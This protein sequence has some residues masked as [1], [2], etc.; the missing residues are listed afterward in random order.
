M[1]NTVS[2][3]SS[4]PKLFVVA[5]I[6]C[7]LS[8]SLAVK[9]YTQAIDYSAG[10]QTDAGVA[11]ADGSAVPVGSLMAFGYYPTAL[12]TPITASS[13]S[14]ILNPGGANA[15]VTL[16]AGT[17]GLDDTLGGFL[18]GLFAA[19]IQSTD[20][21][22]VG[23]QLVYIIGNSFTDLSLSTEVGV[24]TSD[25]W[26][27]P[28][29]GSPVPTLF[30]TDI[31]DV[32]RTTAGIL[33]GSQGIGTPVTDGLIPP[34]DVKQNYNLGVVPE[35]STYALLAMSGIALGGYVIRR[36]RRA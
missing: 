34:G 8:V 1:K 11:L 16:F 17:M 31:T 29:L 5:L 27:I 9:G 3:P 4:S 36:R 15:F 21:T 14:D 22:P 19:G 10:A 2:R 33:F 30:S 12:S 35:P 18:P 26:T 20:A 28:A 7:A 25:S 6:G 32:P 13:M 23:K 24:F